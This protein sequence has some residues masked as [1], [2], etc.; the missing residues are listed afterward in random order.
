M[1]RFQ[2]SKGRQHG[3]AMVMSVLALVVI[4]AFA[5][6]VIDIG[7]LRTNTA[8]LQNALDAGVLAGAQQLPATGA[9][10][11]GATNSVTATVTQYVQANYP[12]YR[13]LTVTF[14]C[15]LPVVSGGS[16]ADTSQ[17]P[18]LC[19]NFPTAPTGGFT[20]H[21]TMCDALCNP[22]VTPPGAPT[23][24]S[25]DMVGAT[26]NDQQPFYLGQLVGV[27]SGTINGG[28]SGGNPESYAANFPASS[29]PVDIV[30]ITDR[31]WSME[32]IET[33]N[34]KNAAYSIVGDPA[35]SPPVA[36]AL[37]YASQWVAFGMLASST[38]GSCV[39]APNDSGDPASTPANLAD[40][41]PVG[42]SGT[43]APSPAPN[44]VSGSDY[45][46][47]IG[48]VTC[49]TNSQGPGTDLADPMIMA[50]YELDKY[51]NPAHRWGI[52]F[53][54]DGEA[55][56]ASETTNSYDPGNYCEQAVT[57]A[58]Q[59]KADTSGALGTPSPKGSSDNMAGN[60]PHT[61]GIEIYTIGFGIGV[62]TGDVTDCTDARG[63]LY[64]DAP[65]SDA[66]VQMASPGAANNTC[67]WSSSDPT[68]YTNENTPIYYGSGK[69][70]STF[71]ETNSLDY[72]PSTAMTYS[73]TQPSNTAPVV[74]H[75]FCVPKTGEVSNLLSG[76]F[77]QIATYLASGTKL[78]QIPE[79]PPVITSI[80]P[81]AGLAA[82]GAT[83]TLTGQYFTNAYAVTVGGTAYTP[84]V[85]S[86][87]KITFTSP[88]GTAGHNV[89]VTVTNPSGAS[90]AVGFSYQ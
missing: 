88:A 68:N 43:G 54:T 49:Y 79:P 25:C 86:D 76:A 35:A 17:I 59:A 7:L 31:T 87:S 20:C 84:T 56:N 5:S 33:T 1:A 46:Q 80:S 4:L 24:E 12:S 32:G 57:A 8:R 37:N 89:T 39:T 83:I 26:A 27:R 73:A 74:D 18:A 36:P 63:S 64:H 2:R 90:N 85:V 21:G 60:T 16:T 41:I 69:Y 82:G 19:P 48:A 11:T 22:S 65:P 72:N 6:I 28:G 70:Y 38:P 66:L 3:Q 61:G 9:A 10:A 67:S 71:D 53:E 30:L 51:G 13:N 55:N 15:L 29:S 52:I 45:T 77:E 34:A 44:Q 23:T 40:W 50:Q 47:I 42:L 62:G 58:D 75:Y 14:Y 78:V 81:A